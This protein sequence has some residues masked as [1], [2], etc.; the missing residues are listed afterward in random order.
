MP[1]RA[2]SDEAVPIPQAASLPLDVDV[3]LPY[4]RQQDLVRDIAFL[5]GTGLADPKFRPQALTKVSAADR[6]YV[7]AVLRRLK[8]LGGRRPS[9]QWRHVG[10]WRI[11]LNREELS[12][13]DVVLAL[14][15]WKG[16]RELPVARWFVTGPPA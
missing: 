6:P 12:A 16:A 4:Y 3:Y 8:A 7:D 10:Q 14:L 15:G 5:C 2:A 1:H 9:C 11:P 13:K